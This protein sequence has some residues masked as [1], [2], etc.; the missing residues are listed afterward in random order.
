MGKNLA[1]EFKVLEGMLE[2]QFYQPRQHL[3]FPRGEAG[4]EES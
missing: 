2:E 3:F 1:E 4:R